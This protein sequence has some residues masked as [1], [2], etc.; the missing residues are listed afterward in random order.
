[1]SYGLPRQRRLP[2]GLHPRPIFRMNQRK[3]FLRRMFARLPPDIAA[4]FGDALNTPRLH[5]RRPAPQPRDRSARASTSARSRATLPP[6]STATTLLFIALPQKPA[7]G[8]RTTT[9]GGHRHK[10]QPL[11]GLK[12]TDVRGIRQQP[13]HHPIRS[14]NPDRPNKSVGQTDPDKPLVLLSLA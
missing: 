14:Q 10:A 12:M 6:R 1:M 8:E 13:I 4:P 2:R 7:H 9:R 11:V 3:Q 5:I